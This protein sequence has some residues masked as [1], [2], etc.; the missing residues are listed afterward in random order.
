MGGLSIPDVE[1]RHASAPTD[2]LAARAFR[3]CASSARIVASIFARFSY[4]GAVFDD[5]QRCQVARFTPICAHKSSTD[6][7]ARFAAASASA[8]RSAISNIVAHSMRNFARV[9]AQ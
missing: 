1:C 9:Q 3:T 6:S 8:R 4:L 5:F 2:L 7:R